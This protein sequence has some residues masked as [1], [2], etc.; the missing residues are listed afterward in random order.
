M[1]QCGLVMPHLDCQPFPEDVLY[2]RLRQED[3]L[4]AH[5]RYNA[6]GRRLQSFLSGLER[7]Y[8]AQKAKAA[9]SLT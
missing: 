7:R 1:S 3:A 4:S 2:E 8:W 5:E 9:T 6:L